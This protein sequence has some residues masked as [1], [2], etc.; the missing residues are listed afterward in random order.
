MALLCGGRVNEG[1][2]GVYPGPGH[3][4]GGGEK[5]REGGPF[6][7]LT[8][9]PPPPG[10]DL[11]RD[12]ALSLTLY[13]GRD[14]GPETGVPTPPPYSPAPFPLWTDRQSETITFPRTS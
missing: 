10:Q 13:P 9:V 14:L 8:G 6:L 5:G 11:H 2:G 3:G 1:W 12:I 4:Q 7:V